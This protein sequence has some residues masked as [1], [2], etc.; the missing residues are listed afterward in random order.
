MK[1]TIDVS[2]LYTGRA[3]IKECENYIK[4]VLELVGEGNEVV[5]KGAAPIWLYLKIAHALHGRAKRLS[6]S[7]PVTGELVVFNHDPF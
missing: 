3:K 1:I 5:L 6:Y 7:S 4:Q 2:S